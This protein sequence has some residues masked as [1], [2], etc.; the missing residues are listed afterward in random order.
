VSNLFRSNSGFLYQKADQRRFAQSSQ[1]QYS[2]SIHRPPCHQS[3]LHPSEWIYDRSPQVV[4]SPVP[5]RLPEWPRGPV[6]ILY[7]S[8]LPTQPGD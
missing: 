7:L 6:Q 2:L 5:I 4:G 1:M 3:H 8:L